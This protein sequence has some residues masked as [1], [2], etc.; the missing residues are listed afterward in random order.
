MSKEPS[1][2]RLI[3]S[4]LVAGAVINICEWGVHVFWLDEAWRAAFAALGKSPT[5]WTTFIPANFWVGIL[6]IWGYRWLS[7]VY[8]SGLKTA[9]RTAVIMW[10]VFWVIPTAAMQPLALFPNPLLAATVLVGFVD[11]GLATL[12]GAWL[13]DGLRENPGIAS[14]VATV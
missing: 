11:G 13:Y 7:R 2:P 6:A 5:G 9:M 1:W 12:L 8:G 10:A 4:G 14:R 3:V